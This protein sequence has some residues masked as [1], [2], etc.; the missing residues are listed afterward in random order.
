MKEWF[1][2][3]REGERDKE[4]MSTRLSSPVLLIKTVNYSVVAE[5]LPDVTGC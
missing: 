2:R 3:L 4:W 5:S 1:V